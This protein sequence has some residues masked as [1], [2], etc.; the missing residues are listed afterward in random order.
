MGIRAV[1][2]MM[3]HGYIS[4]PFPQM[5]TGSGTPRDEQENEGPLAIP[6]LPPQLIGILFLAQQ[7]V[8]DPQVTYVRRF[9]W[10]K[11]PA[12]CAIWMQ[13]LSPVERNDFCTR[14]VLGAIRRIN[15]VILLEVTVKLAFR[16]ITAI[17]VS[18]SA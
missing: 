10:V 17:D 13:A 4:K 6:F 8:H 14:V 15:A 18:Q 2:R 12:V 9:R 7:F 5:E 1:L 11:T 3:G 16:G